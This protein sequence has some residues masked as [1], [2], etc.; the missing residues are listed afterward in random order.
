MLIIDIAIDIEGQT[1]FA[2]HQLSINHDGTIDGPNQVTIFDFLQ[3]L[4][5]NTKTTGAFHFKN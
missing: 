2:R 3:I 4:R 5:I 1:I